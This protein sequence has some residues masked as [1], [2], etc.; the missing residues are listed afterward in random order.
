MSKETDKQI[1]EKKL[2]KAKKKRLAKIFLKEGKIIK[3][4]VARNREYKESLGNELVN[5]LEQE[6]RDWKKN[7]KSA[8]RKVFYGRKD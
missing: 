8:S 3:D 1:Y 5:R 6:T 7:I 2:E 4:S